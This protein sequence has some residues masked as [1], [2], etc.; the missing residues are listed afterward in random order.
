MTHKDSILTALQDGKIHDL[1][2]IV[3]ATQIDRGVLPTVL[4]SLKKAGEIQSPARGKYQ[5]ANGGK[6]GQVHTAYRCGKCNKAYTRDMPCPYCGSTNR[7]VI[8]TSEINAE[9]DHTYGPNSPQPRGFD[10]DDD[11]IFRQDGKETPSEGVELEKDSK[12]QSPTLD[13]FARAFRAD[14]PVSS[15]GHVTLIVPDRIKG[16]DIEN[17]ITALRILINKKE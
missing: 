15:G 17:V 5:K 8:S 7:R 10:T 6:A 9:D 4:G 13:T 16:Q 2:E 12:V 11:G 14:I 3:Q 1:N